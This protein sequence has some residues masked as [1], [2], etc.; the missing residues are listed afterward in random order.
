M[1]DGRIVNLVKG[2]KPHSQPIFRP[3]I[4]ILKKLVELAERSVRKGSVIFR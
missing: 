4:P 2:G 3:F 1:K